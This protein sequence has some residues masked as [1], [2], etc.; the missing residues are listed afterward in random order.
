M[1]TQRD[2]PVRYSFLAL[3]VFFF[4]TLPSQADSTR[5]AREANAGIS[6][7]F[8]GAVSQLEAIEEAR[9]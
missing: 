6:P 3:S 4:A 1:I 8:I 5:D 9:G 7:K 2:N